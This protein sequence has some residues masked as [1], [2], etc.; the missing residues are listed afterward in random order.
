MVCR[1]CQILVTDSFHRLDIPFEKISLGEVTLQRPINRKEKKELEEELAEKGFAILAGKSEQIVNV[2]KSIVLKEIYEGRKT[3]N[4]NL[5]AVLCERL[6]LDYSYISTTFSKSEGKS[7]Q[8]YLLEI[9]VKR[10]KELLEYNELSISEIALELGYSSAAYLSTQFK[11]A[12][13]MSP[14]DYKNQKEKRKI[15]LNVF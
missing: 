14:S 13:G 5:S 8:D 3:G 6:N 11:K 12:T 2:V 1:S 15:D 9:K 10:V 7:I 4:R